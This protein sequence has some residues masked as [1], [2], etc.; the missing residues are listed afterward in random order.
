MP[1]FVRL[2]LSYA[3]SLVSRYMVNPSKEHYLHD[4]SHASMKSRKIGKELVACVDSYF[5]A[6]LDKRRSLTCY[7]FTIGDR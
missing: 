6:D 4:T 5:G 2:D 1:W 3:M 7:V